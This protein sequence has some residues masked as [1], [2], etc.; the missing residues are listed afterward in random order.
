[1]EANAT[2]VMLFKNGDCVSGDSITMEETVLTIHTDYAD[3]IKIDWDDVSELISEKP[4][5]VACHDGAVI[6]DDVGVRDGDGLILFRLEPGAPVQLDNI[7][8]S[9]LVEL[10]YPGNIGLGG[11]T[12]GNT[13]T[14]TINASGTL[15]VN[16][17]WHR[18]I[19]D[20]RANRGKADGK[21][22]AQNTALNT[23]W[24]YF[25]SKRP[26]IP[27]INFLE[28]DKFQDLFFRSATVIGA[29]YDILDRRPTSVHLRYTPGT[30]TTE[31]N[32]AQEILA[33][34]VALDSPAVI[35]HFNN[36]GWQMV[37]ELLVRL[38][39]RGHN[40]WGE[41]Y[42]YAAGQ[43][44]INAAFV[45]PENWVE[46]LGN[47]YEKTMQ[48]PLTGEFY[49]LEKYKKVLTEAPATQIVLYKMSPDA[50]PDWCRLP[51]VVYASDAMMLPGGWDD[52]PKWDTPYEKIPN[53]HPRLAGRHGTCLRIAREQ[54]I[55]LMQIL[56][57]SSY[58]PA[59]YLGDTGLEAMK[60]RGRLQKGMVADITILDPK[61]V[62]DNATYAKGTLPTTG[63]PYVIVNGTVVVKESEVLKEVNPG[64]PIRFPVEDKSRFTPLSL[65]KWTTKFLVAPVGFNGLDIDH[66][67]MH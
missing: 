3:V 47:Q 19:L 1:M 46:K 67:H 63:I 41:I 57:A 31:P 8:A 26:Y 54:D 53:T 15:M 62:R 64:Q 11:A 49:T 16:K 34:A 38:R 58:N 20:G 32:G 21:I 29:G 10:S 12:S 45:K 40:V 22:T 14:E 4:L 9:N 7:K 30:I 23:R 61:T 6:P 33:N 25:L 24:D 27:F 44:T 35:N 39:A 2:D 5:W 50:I 59:K 55:P 18:F 51:G 60:V 65:E 37:Q 13:S 43:K 36:P 17:G 52:E 56:A 48:D 28:Y 42:P 66:E